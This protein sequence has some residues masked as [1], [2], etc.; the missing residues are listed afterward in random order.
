MLRSGFRTIVAAALVT[1]AVA[2]AGTAGAETL[3]FHPTA[4]HGVFLHVSDVHLNPFD[5]IADKTLL[6]RLVKAPISVW[7]SILQSPKN[8]R[9]AQYGEDSNFPLFMS[10]LSAAQGVHYDYVLNT[11][12]NLAHDFREKYLAA[13]G[14]QNRYQEFVIKTLRFVNLMLTKSFPGAPLIYGL[15]NND[16]VCGDYKVAPASRMLAQAG[17]ELSIVAGNRKALKSFA[18]GGYYL[19]PHPTVPRHDMIVLNSV[20]WSAKYDNECNTKVGN[21]GAAELAWLRTTLNREKR[22]K[23]TAT[24]VMHIPP[25]IDSFKSLKHTCTGGITTFWHDAD[26]R[27]FLALVGRGK[28][29]LRVSYAGHTHRDNFRVLSGRNGMPILT[30]RITPS[31]SPVYHNNPAF[32]VLLYDRTDAAVKDYATFYLANLATAG[33][34]VPPAW[35][36]EYTFAKTYNATGY[37][38]ASIAALAKSLRSDASVRKTFLQHYAVEASSSP[39]KAGDWMS[40]ACAQTAM[41][42]AAF[43]ACRCPNGSPPP[44]PTAPH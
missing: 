29:V 27:R 25:G 33:P 37:T 34:T 15:G 30:T 13:G 6:P 11:G 8:E 38:P 39:I 20:F 22:A 23:R 41:T 35:K 44:A 17:R 28:T 31:V 12:D 24:L 40:F 5:P 14:K 9:F 1:L 2:A 10:M 3:P 18:A 21:P 7:E 26:T 4:T 16:A 19:V 32:T 42:R 36:L 43:E